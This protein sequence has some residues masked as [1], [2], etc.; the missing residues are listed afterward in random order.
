QQSGTN[1]GPIT[2]QLVKARGEL[3]KLE[4]GQQLLREQQ[5]RLLLRAPM[6]GIVMRLVQRE[7]LG[8]LAPL[9]TEICSVA[10]TTRLRAL[11]LVSP[12]DK[13]LIE[14]NN[15]ALIRIHGRGYNYWKAHV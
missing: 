6:D 13:D 4:H 3:D 1:S 14:L 15:P 9:G 2:S 12:G 10:D 8:M 11:F 5:D 7:Q